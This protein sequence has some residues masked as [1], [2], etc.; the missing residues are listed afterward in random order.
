MAYL[1]L[2][3]WLTNFARTKILYWHG[4]TFGKQL[5]AAGVGA[6][7][8]E[9]QSCMNV[10]GGAGEGGGQPTGGG[11]DVAHGLKDVFGYLGNVGVNGV[12]IN[13]ILVWIDIQQKSTPENVWM[14]QAEAHFDEHE[15]DLA[16]SSLWKASMDKKEIIGEMIIHKNPGK[17]HRNLVD[18][19]N[20]MKQLKEKTEL[21][22]LM[23]SSDMM[24]RCP[25]F[26][27]P[28]RR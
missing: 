4:V 19:K 24:K 1:S 12:A 7:Q 5:K 23:S 25:A 14:S 9:G 3:R 27:C 2:L 26:H 6:G 15:I 8:A 13:G 10:N 22:L 28:A 20:A 16:R 18:I 11:G 21:P 17:M